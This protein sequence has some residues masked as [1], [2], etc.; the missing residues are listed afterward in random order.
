LNAARDGKNYEGKDIYVVGGADGAIKEA[1]YLSA[2]AKK[3]TV[4]HFESRLGA[5]P[6]FMTNF[7]NLTM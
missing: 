5:I 1:I 4:I 2:F 7:P 3:L 6:Q